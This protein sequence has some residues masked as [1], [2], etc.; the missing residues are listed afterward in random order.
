MARSSTCPVENQ[1][2][3]LYVP[4]NY[5]VVVQLVEQ[6]SPKLYVGSSILSDYAMGYQPRRSRQQT[7]NLSIFVRF[8]D[9]SPKNAGLIQLGECYEEKKKI[10]ILNNRPSRDEL[11]QHLINRESF[12]K[13]GS[14][15]GVTDNAIR[16]WCRYYNL[17]YLARDIKNMSKEELENL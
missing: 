14:Y 15:Y 4:A 9:T 16:K 7:E 13:I 17:P 1:N 3:I 8:E 10:R 2:S 5:V 11:K 12:V 6:Q